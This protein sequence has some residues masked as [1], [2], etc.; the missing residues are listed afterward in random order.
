MKNALPHNG[1]HLYQVGE[2]QL[3]TADGVLLR[4]GAPVSITP[5]MFDVLWLLVQN[6][7]RI[8]AKDELLRAVWSDSFVEEANITVTIGQLRKVLGDDAHTPSYIQTV[9]RRGYRFV[10]PVEEI[11]ERTEP[12]SDAL[13]R[14]NGNGGAV[15]QRSAAQN[16][17]NGKLVADHSGA[18][19]ERIT[20]RYGIKKKR[21]RWAPVVIVVGILAVSVGSF[22]VWQNRTRTIASRLTNLR[23]ERLTDTGNAGGA[24]ISPD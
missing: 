7:G 20:S 24:A 18:L 1:Q 13:P 10:A 15:A 2:F 4:D 19:D 17:G 5:K 9:A 3:N 16:G 22:Y 23:A 12:E 21:F 6:Q 11:R 8:V 14:V